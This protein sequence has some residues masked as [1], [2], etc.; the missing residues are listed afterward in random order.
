MGEP[1]D[2]PILEDP[3]VGLD[4]GLLSSFATSLLYCDPKE[5]PHL[6]TFR[7]QELISVCTKRNNVTYPNEFRLSFVT[8]AYFVLCFYFSLSTS[9]PLEIMVD[10]ALLL[11]FVQIESLV[12]ENIFGVSKLEMRNMAEDFR[13]NSSL[14]IRWKYDIFNEGL[15][16]AREIL[17]DCLNA[18]KTL[19][20]AK[21][22]PKLEE[23]R[24]AIPKLVESYQSC[25]F[26]FFS[27]F[28]LC[29]IAMNIDSV[30]NIHLLPG[31]VESLIVSLLTRPS[32]NSSTAK[33][34]TGLRG[35]VKEIDG[36]EKQKE[37]A[38]SYSSKEYI[39]YV[40]RLTAF[41]V[42]CLF[43]EKLLEQTKL[44]K[45]RLSK[46][47][48]HPSRSPLHHFRIALMIYPA[49]AFVRYRSSSFRVL[50]GVQDSGATSQ[51]APLDGSQAGQ[52][53]NPQA[54]GITPFPVL[55]Y[56]PI[57]LSGRILL[58]RRR[59]AGCDA[60]RPER[61]GRGSLLAV[62]AEVSARG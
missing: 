21:D 59:T 34:P 13:K 54:V 55:F 40:Q 1:R 24:A 41:S 46:L 11:E 44:V 48:T 19:N 27:T 16:M 50:L 7:V 8:L 14:D 4:F 18:A 5:C 60:A 33:S 28:S 17:R 45:S 10:F 62:A 25:C 42:H 6:P 3:S 53:I 49:V 36:K 61:G 9:Y 31:L 12:Y 30:G 20:K 51:S 15:G 26:Y 35:K 22:L 2:I 52:R 58:F 56:R 39:D 23:K 47:F 43:S 37:K 29:H 32:T 57:T 38:L